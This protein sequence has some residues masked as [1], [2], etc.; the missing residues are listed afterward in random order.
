M[1][2]FGVAN[3]VS[4]GFAG[5]LVAKLGRYMLTVL[6][7]LCHLALLGYML[8]Y[9]PKP[10]DYLMYC[11]FAAVWGVCDGL[12]LV[13]INGNFKELFQIYL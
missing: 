5:T 6:C 2:C 3:A 13:I 8:L 10:G 7:A 11:I 12:W 4:A 9:Q 1:I